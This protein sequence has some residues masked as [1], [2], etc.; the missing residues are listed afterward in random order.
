[1]MPGIDVTL[2]YRLVCAEGR[3]MTV[4]KAMN[5]DCVY[6]SVQILVDGGNRALGGN[7]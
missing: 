5:R 2:D 7:T 3:P 1:M 6:Y 4:V